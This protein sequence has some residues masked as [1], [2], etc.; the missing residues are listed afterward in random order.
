MGEHQAPGRGEL[1]ARLGQRLF[2]QLGRDPAVLPVPRL[3]GAAAQAEQVDVLELEPLDLLRLGDQHGA[4][5][6][7]IAVLAPELPGIGDRV[8]MAHEV[9][10]RTARLAA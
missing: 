5:D 4:G 9:A 6:R 3:D 2:E 7:A 8:E 1:V 10:R